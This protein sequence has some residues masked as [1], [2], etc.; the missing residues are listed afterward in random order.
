MAEVINNQAAPVPAA[1]P[2]EKS[3][4][5]LLA[6]LWGVSVEEARKRDEEHLAQVQADSDAAEK[7]AADAMAGAP[8][9]PATAAPKKSGVADSQA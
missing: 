7:A 2:A 3:R 1:P 5:E 6:E 9:K 4:H 8:A